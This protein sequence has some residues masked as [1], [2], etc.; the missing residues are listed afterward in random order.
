M[1]FLSVVA[2]LVFI[3]LGFWQLDRLEQR[4]IFNARVLSQIN[5][6]VFSLQGDALNKDLYELEY[7]SVTVSGRYDFENEIAIRNQAFENQVGVHLVT[8]L[9]ISGTDQAI[10]VDRG[11]IP[12]ADFRNE[13]WSKFAENGEVEV[14][15]VLRR[16][17]TKPD[18]GSRTD[19]TPAPG[20]PRRIA[21]F[22]VNVDGIQKQIPYELMKGAYIQQEPDP[23]WDGFPKRSTSEV[24][25]SEGSHQSYALQWFSFALIALL[26]VP[27]LV[28]QQS[29][30]ER[31]SGLISEDFNK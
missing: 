4:R 15:G 23:K 6:P 24:E 12:D 14:V 19:P 5:Q 17:R 21:W 8:P 30:K 31:K 9:I 3:R 25:I 1:T 26:G 18:F 10:L 13:D 28:Y 16:S 27:A 20:E 29:L 22:F 11:W 2:A 7:R